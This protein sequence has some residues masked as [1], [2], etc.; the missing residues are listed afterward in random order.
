VSP[1]YADAL[2]NQPRGAD[3]SRQNGKQ[4]PLARLLL[5]ALRTHPA[6]TLDAQVAQL[7]VTEVVLAAAFHRITPA[8]YRYAAS[9]GGT[10]PAWI[11]PLAR[12]RHDQLM[13]HLR[14][15]ADLEVVAAVLDNA[16]VPWAAIKGPVLAENIWSRSDLR[17]YT[18]LDILVD[19]R[20]FARA[21]DALT[22]AG[23][24]SLDR[25]WPLVRSTM[26][27]ELAM[28]LEHGSHLDLH[29]DVVVPSELRRTFRFPVDEMLER[30]VLI[31]VGKVLV[32]T[33]DPVDTL[34]HLAFHAAHSGGHRL[35]WLADIGYA[36]RVP[37]LDWDAA[38]N[39]ALAAHVDVLLA[40]L[41]ERA[42]R[43]LCLGPEPPERIL[44][45]ARRPWGRF[46]R[47]AERFAPVPLLPTDTRSATNLV[48]GTRPTLIGSIAATARSHRDNRQI[49]RRLV[50]GQPTSR[51]LREEH[52]DPDARADYLAVVQ[53]ADCP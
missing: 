53:Y 42:H 36:S 32:P 1:G 34:L 47:A 9:A 11:P 43:V 35:V 50:P 33:F 21:L 41:L 40:V 37:T 4:R 20:Y 30:R 12:R 19:R 23:A 16:D 31:P 39:R 2:G 26:R 17:E 22:E 7:S 49:E 24:S 45:P 29:W 6:S 25:N 13:R 28:V 3:V 46:V 15:L 27:A 44:A 18:D 8:V 14:T 52:D 48:A 38:M 51:P 10:P 5:D